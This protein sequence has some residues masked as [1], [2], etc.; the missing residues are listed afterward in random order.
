[1][2]QLLRGLNGNS[3]QWVSGTTK[4]ETLYQLFDRMKSGQQSPDS[5]VPASYFTFGFVRNPW[6]RVSS[7]YRYLN[8]KRPRPEIASVTS[9]EDFIEQ[10]G[11]GVPWIRGLHSMRPQIDFFRRTPTSMPEA[12]F[13][14]HYEHLA[15]DF[16]NVARLLGLPA[17]ELPHLNRSSNSRADYRNSYSARSAEIVAHLFQRD[18]E[19]FGYSF[20]QRLPLKR[21]SG[22]VK[23]LSGNLRYQVI[24]P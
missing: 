6:E 5:D 19:A 24:L 22:P 21:C 7:L 20:D 8:E 23:A 15:E 18:I 4:H 2:M 12:D 13:I 3:V 9:V 1:M 14:G 17:V 16:S 11:S 10:A